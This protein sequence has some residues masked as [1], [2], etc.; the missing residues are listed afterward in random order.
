MSVNKYNPAT[1]NLKRYDGTMVDSTPTQNSGNPVSSGGVYSALEGKQDKADEG[2]VDIDVSQQVITSGHESINITT[3]IPSGYIPYS[4]VWC[5][6][7][8]DENINFYPL[9]IPNSNGSYLCVIGPAN[10][11][12]YTNCV[13]RVFYRKIS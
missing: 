8:W 3:D 6:S 10:H 2:Y 1:G 13:I 5:G 11:T 4:A 7:N 9:Y 12:I